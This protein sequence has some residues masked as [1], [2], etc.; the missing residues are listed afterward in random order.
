MTVKRLELKHKRPDIALMHR[1]YCDY[2]RDHQPRDKNQNKTLTKIEHE[3]SISE[4]WDPDISTMRKLQFFKFISY[5]SFKQNFKK[6]K[7]SADLRWV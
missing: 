6:S 5:I 3:L 1:D 2:L 7:Y 4:F